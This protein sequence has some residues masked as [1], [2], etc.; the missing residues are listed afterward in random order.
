MSQFMIL[1]ILNTIKKIIAYC[2]KWN[3]N[4]YYNEK[5]NIN[6]NFKNR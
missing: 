1:T 2:F 5:Y 6:L 4:C 3:Q